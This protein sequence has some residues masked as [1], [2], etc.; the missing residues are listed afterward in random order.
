MKRIIIKFFIYTSVLIGIH[1]FAAYQAD[2]HFDSYYLRF[3]NGQHRSMIL[4]TSRAAQG[5]NPAVID[6]ILGNYS[7][8][9]NFAFANVSSPYG[10]V[11]FE[12]IRKKIDTTATDKKNIFILAVSPWSISTLDKSDDISKFRERNLF[13]TKIKS[14]N[15]KGKPNFEYLMKE[16]A[17]SW[18][19]IL[20]N[21]VDNQ[22]FLHDNGWLEISVSMNRSEVQK[23][24]S[25]KVIAY[26]TNA[27]VYQYSP[28]RMNYLKQTILFLKKYGS[29][30]L[31]RL[32]I[33]EPMGAVES[34][35]MPEFDTKMNLLS[36]EHNLKY[37]SFAPQNANYDYTDG[38]HLYYKSSLKVS[39]VLAKWIRNN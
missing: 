20:Y 8:I 7:P 38:N 26:H 4:G 24:T 1:I 11:Y 29:V 23:R 34:K 19:K 31:V 2:G 32:P 18:G 28:N 17:Q 9:G 12:A 37:W 30:H 6:S 25:E 13:L 5:L 22:A 36:Q 35:Y 16:Y 3:T 10:Q 33:S 39:E 14:I 15:K 21:P 27:T